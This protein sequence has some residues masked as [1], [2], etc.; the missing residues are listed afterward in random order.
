LVVEEERWQEGAARKWE[1][2]PVDGKIGGN[3]RKDTI[4]AEKTYP[5]SESKSLN[6]L[7]HLTPTHF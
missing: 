5:S 2:D 4:L 1:M 3:W 6:S 7:K